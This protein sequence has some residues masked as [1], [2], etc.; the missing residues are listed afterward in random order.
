MQACQWQCQVCTCSNSA[1]HD[2]CEECGST[3]SPD[4]AGVSLWRKVLGGSGLLAA[5]AGALWLKFAWTM[6]LMGI[7]WLMLLGGF[8]AAWL[9]TS[10]NNAP[11]APSPP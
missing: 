11:S 6:Q 1:A 2:T 4:R 9:A 5:G 8:L 7:A 10:W 3:A